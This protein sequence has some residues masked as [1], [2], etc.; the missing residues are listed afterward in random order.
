VLLSAGF[1]F[2]DSGGIPDV[3]GD[4]EFLHQ[5]QKPS[6]RSGRFDTDH[7]RRRQVRVEVAH[8]RPFVQQRA[9]DDFSCFAIQHRDRLLRCVQIA[10]DHAHL[11]LLRPERC[12]GGHRTV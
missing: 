4:V 9:L 5:P 6:H 10:A 2:S 8:R 12:D 1:D 11:G 7:D 3:A